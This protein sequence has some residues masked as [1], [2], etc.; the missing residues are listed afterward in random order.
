MSLMPS[1]KTQVACSAT[2]AAGN[3]ASTVFQV[4][5]RA[6]KTSGSATTVIGGDRRCMTPGMFAWI[7]AE[8]FTSGATVTIQLQSSSL[9]V[10]RL[11]TVRA[12]RK[13]RVRQ[14][15]RIPAASSGDAD[16]VVIGPAGKDDLVHM[17]PV[18][19]ARASARHGG[20]LISIL[21]NRN[22]D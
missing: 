5:V 16:V 7:E 12:D 9:D 19:V 17:L 14:L 22:C 20:K 3:A 13:G 21:R 2:D 4:T 11:Q 1:G 6:P 10:T 15:V 18:R 8:G